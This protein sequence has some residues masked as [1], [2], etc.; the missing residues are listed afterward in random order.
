[1]ETWA[2]QMI[3]TLQDYYLY[4]RQ[5]KKQGFNLAFQKYLN[6]L[7]GLKELNSLPKICTAGT[8]FQQVSLF[9]SK[10]LLLL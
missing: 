9:T 5:Y 3:K 10:N 7:D 1:M 4:L 2:A 6:L 8:C